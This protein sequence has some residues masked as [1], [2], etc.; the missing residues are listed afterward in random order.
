MVKEGGKDP[1]ARVRYG[2]R[3]ATA[4]TPAPEEV[5][6][7]LHIVQGQLADYRRDRKAARAL[8]AVGESGHDPRVDPT[9]LAAW[10]TLASVILNLDETITKE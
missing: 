3:L 1:A 5:D 9:E 7:L 8:L 4:R 10:T 6:I 2:F